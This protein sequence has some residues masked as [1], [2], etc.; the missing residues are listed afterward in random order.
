MYIPV[1]RIQFVMSRTWIE[2]MI[3]RNAFVISLIRIRDGPILC[4]PT[5]VSETVCWSQGCKRDVEV[6]DRDETETLGF[7]SE[8]R[9]RPRPYHFSRDR[10][11]DRDIQFGVRDETETETL[12]GRDRDIFRDLGTLSL[13]SE[14]FLPC[15]SF[16]SKLTKF[17]NSKVC[18]AVSL[19]TWHYKI[20]IPRK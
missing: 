3:S 14:V 6:R 8:T 9:P 18:R 1:S 17:K 2:F 20:S 12:I 19:G 16:Y 4:S 13:I 11:R 15:I 10:D 5:F 7:Q